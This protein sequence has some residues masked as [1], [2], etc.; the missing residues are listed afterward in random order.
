MFHPLPLCIFSRIDSDVPGLMSYPRR[1]SQFT[2]AS[3]S[4]ELET[5]DSEQALIL[6]ELHVSMLLH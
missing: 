1:K 4:T 2:S 5:F 6:V 3:G